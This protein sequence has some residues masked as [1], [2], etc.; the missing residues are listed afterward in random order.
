[1]RNIILFTWQ[2][3]QTLLGYFLIFF[4]KFI[5]GRKIDSFYYYETTVYFIEDFPSKNNISGVALGKVIILDY[6]RFFQKE[7]SLITIKHEYGHVL[8]GYYFGPL[9]LILIGI[10]SIVQNI[11]SMFKSMD[12]RRRYYDRYPENWADELGG[13]TVEERTNLGW[14]VTSRNKN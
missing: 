12:Y 7:N 4:Y 10:P 5:L 14:I 1:M 2:L 11:L 9:Y 6:N 3:P 13:V 8:Q